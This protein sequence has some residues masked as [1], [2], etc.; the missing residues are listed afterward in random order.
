MSFYEV[1]EVNKKANDSEIK[2]AYRQKSL[3]YHP[4]RNHGLGAS[5]KMKQINE[6]YTVLSDKSKRRQYDLEQELGD[7]PF[8]F[9]SQATGMPFTHGGT[10]DDSHQEINELF[11]TLFGNMMNP[12][13]MNPTMG[14]NE[15]PNVRIF[16]GGI[17]SEHLFQKQTN[18]YS[19]PEPLTI[20]LNITL[21]QAY[22]GC[23]I[24]VNINRWIMIG[25][26][27]INE[28][29]T[30]YV[31]VYEGIDDNEIL[32]LEQK[33]NVTTEQVKGDV[34]ISIH[35]ENNGH[36]QRSGLDLLYNKT[37]SLKEALC[38]FSFDLEHINNKRLAFNNK[39]NINVIKPNYRK[40]I[41]NMGMKRKDNV[42]NLIVTFH[43]EFPEKLT[44]EQQESL[45]NIL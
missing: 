12:N 6:A 39:S 2:K 7:N 31:N 43:V 13:M 44:Q 1:L 35:I 10:N 37:I 9:F 19:K 28:E 41:P 17:P 25:E 30:T 34:K 22:N 23:T 26:T 5:D 33:G 21:E 42:G 11:S 40:K 3:H 15:M 8:S 45:S 14:G 20:P 32:T 24:P 18:Q 38:G 27:K 36:F 29:E 4:D 16:H